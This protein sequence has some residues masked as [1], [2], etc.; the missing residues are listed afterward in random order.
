[1]KAAGSGPPC[2]SSGGG[3]RTHNLSVNSRSLLPIELPRNAQPP[4][5]R[6]VAP[7]ILG[8]LSGT[9]LDLGV[10]VGTEQHAFAGLGARTLERPTDP[11]L[12]EREPLA[13]GVEMMELKR[14]RVPVVAA[15]P[16]A[17]TRFRD[18]DRLDLAPPAHNRLGPAAQARVAPARSTPVDRRPV[19][20]ALELSVICSKR[21]RVPG[22]P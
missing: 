4:H 9:R 5:H 13:V 21:S 8:K 19:H 12:A 1:T 18:E 20:G 17:T 3:T 7:H 16:A 2:V 15:E 11:L 14:G 22:G 10:A 6:Q